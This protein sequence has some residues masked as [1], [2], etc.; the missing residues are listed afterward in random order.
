MSDVTTSDLGTFLRATGAP[1]GSADLAAA[2]AIVGG[3]FSVDDTPYTGPGDHYLVAPTGEVS[4]LIQRDVATAIFLRIRG[5]EG[6][7]AYSRVSGLFP[8]S[9]TAPAREE[10]RGLLGEPMRSAGGYDLFQV[11]GRFAHFE[12]DADGLSLITLM[13]EDPLA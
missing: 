7:E 11:D 8:G 6:F 3:E 4:I 12:Y 5:G 9:T 2:M 1:E 13:D 10:I